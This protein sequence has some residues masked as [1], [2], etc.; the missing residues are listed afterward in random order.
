MSEPFSFAYSRLFEVRLL[1]HYWLDDGATAFDD[2]A[3]DA[4]KAA[5]L[6]DYD[7]RQFLEVVPTA[8]TQT[9]LAGYGCLFKSQA[10]GFLVAAP[11]AA[12]FPLDQRFDFII[13]VIDQRFLDYTALTLSSRAIYE[14]IGSDDTTYRYKENVAVWSNLNGSTRGV[15]PDLKTFLSREIP[16][17]T[18]ADSV[19]SLVVSGGKLLQ[20]TSDDPAATTQELN[21]ASTNAP[22]YAHQDDSPTI[23]PA[24][25]VVGAPARGVEL[26]DDIADDVYALVSLTAT[27]PTKSELSFVDGSGRVKDPAP[28]FE[29]RFKN[30]STFWSYFDKSTGAVKSTETDALPL[31]FFGNAGAQQKPA[32]RSLKVEMSGS[33]VA[34][35]VSEIYV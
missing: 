1:H 14:L 15:S 31:T 10:L 5:R 25:G 30:R 13:R 6:A 26:T 4:T 35:L 2:I 22:V 23:T 9:V 24:A 28:V 18:G 17:P 32:E 7:V 12:E 8:D 11:S 20:L 27:H 21:A 33:K 19:E 3:S 16:A 34:K 29:V